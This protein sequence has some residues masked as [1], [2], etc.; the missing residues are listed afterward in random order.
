MRATC[1]H[2]S[3]PHRLVLRADARGRRLFVGFRLGDR[4]LDRVRRHRCTDHRRP[5]RTDTEPD[6][7][8]PV[9][10]EPVDTLPAETDPVD[11]GPTDVSEG[12]SDARGVVEVLASDEL[13]GRDNFTAGSTAAQEFLVGQLSEFAE[14]AFDAAGSDGYLQEFP[15]GT[16]L[17]A[18]IPGTDLADEYVVVG[19]HY[20]HVGADCP[21]IDMDD[22]I[23]NGA[24]DNAA[25]VAVAI[26]AARHVA[27]AGAPRRTIVIALW[28]A[29]E[30]GLLGS[31]YY[32]S[33]PVVP[34][35]RTVAYVNFDIQGSDL[36][37][38]IANSTIAVG[39]ET[40]GPTLVESVA[41]AAGSSTLDTEQLSVIFG[42]GRSDHAS[43]VSNGVPAVF[44]TDATNACYHTAQDDVTAVNFDKLDQQVVTATA[45]LADLAST[46]AVPVFDAAAPVATYDDAVALLAIAEPAQADFA[47]LGPEGEAVSTQ[48]LVDLRAVV[49]AGPDAFTEDSIGTLLGGAA[50]F[51]EALSRGTCAPRPLNS[52]PPNSQCVT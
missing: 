11:S 1:V 19:A 35:D 17:L 49:D 50:G 33:D 9:D 45:L 32:A 16:N 25:G 34:L 26:T 39:A 21:T 8:E 15:D 44:L 7:T 5:T 36:V 41:T 29:E 48:L 31:T 37:P 12:A 52:R 20:D 3:N 51:I 23:C 24:T 2:A 6:D 18:V 22:H 13:A 46:D 43:F 28:D 10:T 42:Q 47:S 38:S 4:R 40:G 14:P 27:A 30:D